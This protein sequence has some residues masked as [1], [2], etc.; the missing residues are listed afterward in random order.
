MW[1]FDEHDG[2]DLYVCN[3]HHQCEHGHESERN[4]HRRLDT[5]VRL[6]VFDICDDCN[7]VAVALDD[8]SIVT[9]Y[10]EDTLANRDPDP[11]GD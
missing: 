5:C 9:D 2:A 11:N 8:Y 1:G 10:G 3:R 7:S 6:G 4:D